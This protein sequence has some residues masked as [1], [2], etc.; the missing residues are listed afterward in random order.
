MPSDVKSGLQSSVQFGIQIKNYCFIDSSSAPAECRNLLDDSMKI[1]EKNTSDLHR[2][3]YRIYNLVT[4]IVTELKMVSLKSDKPK[5]DCQPFSVLHR[6]LWLSCL[7]L[8]KLICSVPLE[9]LDSSFPFA[10]PKTTYA[11][12]PRVDYLNVLNFLKRRG[13]HLVSYGIFFQKNCNNAHLGF[14]VIYLQL[15]IPFAFGKYSSR[16][17]KATLHCSVPV[18]DSAKGG[19]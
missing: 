17:N 4:A 15:P 6:I 18:D 2:K 19:G 11:S 13:Y 7:E 12:S 16:L 5:K 10:I 3:Y 1:E 9:I 8:Q 14:R